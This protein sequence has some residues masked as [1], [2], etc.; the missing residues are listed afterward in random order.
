L[1]AAIHG[2]SADLLRDVPFDLPVVET[3]RHLPEWWDG[4]GPLGLR[5]E[6]IPRTARVLAVAN[7]FVAMISG[8]AYRRAMTFDDAADILLE[9]AGSK[10]DRAVVVALIN[11][12]ENRGGGAK[13]SDF[14]KTRDELLG[15][16]PPHR[17]HGPAEGPAITT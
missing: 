14:V 15:L 2:V 6:R 4:S 16:A 8:R 1:I 12:V 3:I 17:A 11:Y 9:Q 10:F 13:W 5:G 7:A